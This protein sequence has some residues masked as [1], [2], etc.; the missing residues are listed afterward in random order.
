MVPFGRLRYG[1]ELEA[2]NT[3]F[4]NRLRWHYAVAFLG[5]ERQRHRGNVED[6]AGTGGTRAARFSS[7]GRPLACLFASIRNTN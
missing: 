1:L 6:G 5:M 7:A 2:I 4:C 3:K